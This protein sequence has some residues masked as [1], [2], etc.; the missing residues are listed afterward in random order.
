MKRINMVRKNLLKS[1]KKAI[2]KIEPDAQIILYGSQSRGDSTSESDWDFLILVDGPIDDNRIDRI[3][4]L[5][6]EIE[7][8]SG[9]VIS[10]IMRNRREWNSYPYTSTPFFENITREG[11]AL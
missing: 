11:I 9:Q 6:Y 7:W 10:S 5:L 2:H 4:H 1:V 3:R 8:D